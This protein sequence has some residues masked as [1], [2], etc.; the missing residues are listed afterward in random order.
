MDD[1]RNPTGGVQNVTANEKSAKTKGSEETRDVKRGRGR[2]RKNPA[3]T[4]PLKSNTSD[5]AAVDACVCK[6]Y[7]ANEVSVACDTC[8]VYWHLCCVGLKGLTEAMM[9]SVEHW[10]CPRCFSCP[11]VEQER[12]CSTPAA[13]TPEHRTLQLLIKEELNLINPVIRATIKDA[14]RTAMPSEVC[15]KVDVKVM[16]EESASKAVKSYADITA[17]S[18][19]KV[20]DEMSLLQASK[21]VV[22]EVSRKMNTDKVERENRKFNVCVLK[23]PESTRKDPK[24]RQGDD[25]KFCKETLKID[26]KDMVVCHR[27]GK[28]DSTKPD[29]CRPL[30]IEMV[31][32]ECVDYYTNNGKGWKE[33]DYWINLDLC[34]VDRDAR[35]LV[36]KEAEKRRE[37]AAKKRKEKEKKEELKKAVASNH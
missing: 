35:F 5:V 34:K 2:P 29:Y 33:S 15:K 21:N 18:Q 31:D 1:D 19:K 17:T 12:T 25:F 27:A 13:T 7:I 24:H 26:K 6:A 11:I 23:V 37:E 16:L 22:E 20:L 4:S 8:S 36:R 28:L 3:K 14:L 32:K 9:D 10:D 30:I